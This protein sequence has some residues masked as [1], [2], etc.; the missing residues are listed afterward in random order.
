MKPALI[1]LLAL[2]LSLPA[3]AQN[4]TTP[5]VNLAKQTWKVDSISGLGAS[6]PTTDKLRKELGT[7]NITF[8]D[9]SRA[10]ILLDDQIV[11][12]NY[13]LSKG[14]K[15]TYLNFSGVFLLYVRILEAKENALVLGFEFPKIANSD[16]GKFHLSKAGYSLADSLQA[17]FPGNYLLE[18]YMYVSGFDRN[19]DRLHL[20]G[21]THMRLSD[22][23]T[24]ICNFGTLD[25][26]T[27][28]LDAKKMEIQLQGRQK[29]Y[30]FSIEGYLASTV[31]LK[32]LAGTWDT[33]FTLYRSPFA[34][35]DEDDE[36]M[37]EAVAEAPPMYEEE[38][39]DQMVVDSLPDDYET[40]EYSPEKTQSEML[41]DSWQ[42]YATVDNGEFV[43]LESGTYLI[44]YP[45]GTVYYNKGRKK[46]KGTWTLKER[47]Q[48]LVL[49]WNKKEEVAQYWWDYYYYDDSY[50][51]KNSLNIVF[52]PPGEKKAITVEFRRV[53]SE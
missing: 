46:T 45:D 5:P 50:D 53:A 19:G 35:F 41:C 7:L 9:N 3:S 39:T 33:T 22:D 10:L 38:M 29:L 4:K 44:F 49:S 12:V 8:L 6:N 24:M 20:A 17:H 21:T 47:S 11:L 36:Y 14:S 31:R 25:T 52:T 15:G 16:G 42:A 26:G 30:H 37:T 27:W 43:S 13:D 34:N 32:G 23:G 51:T 2:F 40:V 1:T 48:T 28:S 18:E